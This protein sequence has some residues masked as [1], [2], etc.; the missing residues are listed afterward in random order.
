MARPGASWRL[1]HVRQGRT[2]ATVDKPA[3]PL[4]KPQKYQEFLANTLAFRPIKVRLL[5]TTCALV[6]TGTD[7]SHA[8][9][10]RREIPGRLF[11]AVKKPGHVR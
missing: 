7:T 3:S 1:P 8:R 5:A 2:T 6:E 4:R 10:S 9:Q 11:V